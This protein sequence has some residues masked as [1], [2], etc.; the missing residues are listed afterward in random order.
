MAL[1]AVEYL[2]AGEAEAATETNNGQ[3]DRPWQLWKQR[4]VEAGRA[5]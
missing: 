1:G 5:P 2:S 4:L 3:L